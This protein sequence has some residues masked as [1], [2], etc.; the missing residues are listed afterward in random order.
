MYIVHFKLVPSFLYL[1][2]EAFWL[3]LVW[4]PLFYLHTASGETFQ[5][6]SSGGYWP[7]L[8][9]HTAYVLC[10]SCPF[11]ILVGLVSDNFFRT[12]LYLLFLFPVSCVSP[13]FLSALLRC[14]TRAIVFNTLFL[15]NVEWYLFCFVDISHTIQLW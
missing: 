5:K 4:K 1:T 3:L 7:L 11:K 8:M 12:S 10:Y 13:L 15:L 9:I 2:T 14:C 6:Q